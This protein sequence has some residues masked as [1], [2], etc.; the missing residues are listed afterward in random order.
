M[1]LFCFLMFFAVWGR[2]VPLQLDVNRI[3]VGAIAGVKIIKEIQF[4]SIFTQI[5][6]VVISGIQYPDVYFTKIIQIQQTGFSIEVLSAENTT[7]IYN[8]IA[9]VD[10]RVQVSC[11]NYKTKENVFIGFQKAYVKLPNA[12]TFLTGKKE[13]QVQISQEILKDGVLLTI[14]GDSQ[15]VGTC[16]IAATYDVLQF[17]KQVGATLFQ[18]PKE[19][20]SIIAQAS[21]LCDDECGIYYQ[22]SA[23]SQE[24]QNRFD[25]SLNMLINAANNE[26]QNGNTQVNH[27]QNLNELVTKNSNVEQNDQVQIIKTKVIP[28]KQ[29]SNQ[30]N[31]L[32]MI[33]LQLNEQINKLEEFEKQHHV[34][35]EQPE[36][37]EIKQK[38]DQFEISKEIPVVIKE[39]QKPIQQK[40]E[41][42]EKQQP[43]SQSQP[44]SQHQSQTQSQPQSSQQP[45]SQAKR[46][47]A[48]INDQ[49][50][51]TTLKDQFSSLRDIA[52][53]Q[54]K[55]VQ[56]PFE[57]GN[58]E[59]IEVYHISQESTSRAE[60]LINLKTIDRVQK[61]S[62]KVQKMVEQA[63]Q[64]VKFDDSFNQQ[65]PQQV[66]TIAKEPL[67]DQPTKQKPKVIDQEEKQSIQKGNLRK[68]E[69]NYEA[70][71]IDDKPVQTKKENKLKEYLEKAEKSNLEINKPLDIPEPEEKPY[72]Q[73]IQDSEYIP[74][75][76]Q[77]NERKTQILE[78][79]KEKYKVKKINDNMDV[80][81]IPAPESIPTILL[82]QYL[83]QLKKTTPIMEEKPKVVVDKKIDSAYE[84]E[85]AFYEWTLHGNDK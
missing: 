73:F 38:T 18:G 25:S 1:K 78:E 59:H 19:I 43:K 51:S 65:P 14:N 67:L 62:P 53:Q 24:Q 28:E 85:A 4:N 72:I 26:L 27:L 56:I 9:I 83:D 5:P 40:Q 64:G 33:N 34:Q 44:Q 61:L 42:Q 71:L 22:Q 79:L 63:K 81:L 57:K 70:P 31:P 49:D 20:I 58:E 23:R 16:T 55:N 8:Y 41:K 66:E 54:T 50:V 15:V 29:Q 45:Q 46:V 36:N 32:E 12:I 75:T 52:Y 60:Q 3:D 69:L 6:K 10:D 68:Q 21:V 39:Q 47:W 13:H 35:I 82:Q 80:D 30:T 2:N 48:R 11:L 17:T 7:I 84:L 77:L 74:Y 76:Q 37:L